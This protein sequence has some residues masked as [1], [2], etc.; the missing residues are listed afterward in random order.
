MGTPGAIVRGAIGLK[1]G[2]GGGLLRFNAAGS[3][4]CCCGVVACGAPLGLLTPPF[5]MD[6]CVDASIAAVSALTVTIFWR[7]TAETI[8]N[9]DLSNVRW[10]RQQIYQLDASYSVTVS[11]HPTT[12]ALTGAVAGSVTYYGREIIT[13]AVFGDP[14]YSG[15]DD[16]TQVVTGSTFQTYATQQ[17]LFALGGAST[18]WRFASG[19]GTDPRFIGIPNLIDARAILAYQWNGGGNGSGMSAWKWN[20]SN[21]GLWRDSGGS[22]RFTMHPSRLPA[23][24]DLARPCPDGGTTYSG[25]GSYSF[26]RHDEGENM[27]GGA[28][29][30]YTQDTT[31]SQVIGYTAC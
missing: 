7:A 15:D 22:A 21:L 5:G 28:R 8:F 23:G 13:P 6:G 24:G 11:R 1:R 9:A 25:H 4:D 30:T 26:T 27:S 29:N 3:A 18:R 2:P 19:F 14:G 17:D 31:G 20:T 16:A 12:N 10:V